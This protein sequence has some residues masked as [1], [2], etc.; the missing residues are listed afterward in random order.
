[1]TAALFLLATLVAQTTPPPAQ[2]PAQP[3]A[4][5]H[6]AVAAVYVPERVYDTRR[7]AF[8]DF[9]VM[10][11]DL[12]R[13]DVIFVGEQ[14]DDPN[15]HRLESAVLQ[16]LMRRGVPLTVSLEMFERD[17]QPAL[18]RYLAGAIPEEEF[19]KS[20][21][22]WP[23]YATDYRPLIEMAK[24]HKWRV[25]ASNVPRRLASDV[26][27]G[28]RG[29]LESIAASDRAFIA[30]D[31]QCPEDAYFERFKATMGGHPVAGADKDKDKAE[32]EARATNERYYWSQC[33]K[34]ETMAESIVA[35]FEKQAGAAGAIVHYNG[36]F[37]SDFGLGAAERVRRRL[38]GRRVAVVTVLPVTDL[39]N[40]TPDEED[41]TRGEYLIYTIGK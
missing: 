1:M 26:A 31:L 21:R 4:S 18:D 24:A 11:A 33:L 17:V 41:L 29:V 2:P 35:A 20:S 14:H 28:G 16:G 19:L 23:R 22:P 34:D 8:T 39:D 25:L 37:H 15:T 36:A 13:A 32:A 5:P 6:V 38:P 10:L 9:E 3:P 40:L 30:R 12:A 7:K 27:K